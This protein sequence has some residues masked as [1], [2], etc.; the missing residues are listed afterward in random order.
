[1]EP[2]KGVKT[3]IEA[4]IELLHRRRRIDVC[5]LLC[6]NKGE[7]SKPYEELYKNLPISKLIRFAGYRRDLD[8]LYPS[9]FC[10][11]IPSTGW[12]SFPRSSLEMASS[13][14][15]VIASRLQGLPECVLDRKTGLLYTP[16]NT[17]ELVDA[18]EILLQNPELA[19]RYGKAG[20]ARCEKT[21]NLVSQRENLQAVLS[22]RLAATSLG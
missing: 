19:E 1:M 17:Q 10:G 16:G 12:D 3:L 2:R 20:R 14:L 9:C 6:G 5:F 21:L 11:V 4:A 7:E 15:P 8:L 22:K 18:I 13:G